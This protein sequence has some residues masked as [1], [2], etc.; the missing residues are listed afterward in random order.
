MLPLGITPSS[1][2]KTAGR[3]LLIEEIDDSISDNRTNLLVDSYNKGGGGPTS[4]FITESNVSKAANFYSTTSKES[5]STPTEFG[6][7]WA[8]RTG[9]LI[10]EVEGNNPT[11]T[12]MARVEVIEDL[13]DMETPQLHSEEDQSANT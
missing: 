4:F 1:S 3:R 2:N 10:E 13:E 5:E 8:E 11:K 7:Q 9:P 12:E 6:G